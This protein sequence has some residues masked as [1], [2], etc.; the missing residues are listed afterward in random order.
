MVEPREFPCGEDAPDGARVSTGCGEPGI[1]GTSLVTEG[2]LLGFEAMTSGAT[3]PGGG[4]RGSDVIVPDGIASTGA[5]SG[6][7]RAGTGRDAA[8]VSRP[9]KRAD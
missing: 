2:T 3:P 5:G 1:T 9:P 8:T 7:L 6:T 4:G